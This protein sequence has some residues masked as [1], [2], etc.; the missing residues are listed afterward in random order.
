MVMAS[1]VYVTIVQQCL[2]APEMDVK[3]EACYCVANFLEFQEADFYEYLLQLDVLYPLCETLRIGDAKILVVA[4]EAVLSFLEYGR[5]LQEATGSEVNP[6][7]QAIEG[8]NAL[9]LLEALQTNRDHEV[10]ELALTIL[11]DFF[12]TEPEYE[13]QQLEFGAPG[14]NDGAP[15]NF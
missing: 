3:K 7:A 9:E 15:F 12:N 5:A 4:L 10:Y 11:D 1:G 13:H 8:H 14:P 2:L 6:V